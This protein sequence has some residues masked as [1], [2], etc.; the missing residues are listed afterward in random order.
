MKGCYID[1]G[2][3][4]QCLE[5]GHSAGETNPSVRT[6]GRPASREL[7][8][9]QTATSR[10]SSLQ[11]SQVLGQ[12]QQPKMKLCP[13]ACMLENLSKTMW[14]LEQQVDMTRLLGYGEVWRRTDCEEACYCLHLVFLLTLRRFLKFKKRKLLH[15]FCMSVRRG[16]IRS[17][18]KS[19]YR[20]L[21]AK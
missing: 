16:S 3:R 18:N 7:P 14:K 2:R 4:R 6:A 1:V 5:S 8:L 19:N 12:M 15:L 17:G 21:K 10:R 11:R 20:C 13:Q 9:H